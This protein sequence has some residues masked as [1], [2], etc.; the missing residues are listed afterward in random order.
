MGK[1]VYIL[2]FSYL[3]GKALRP[4]LEDP[5][6]RTNEGKGQM[7][8]ADAKSEFQIICSRIVSSR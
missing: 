8:F 3:R 6:L 2:S 7:L 5:Q 4:L 1:V